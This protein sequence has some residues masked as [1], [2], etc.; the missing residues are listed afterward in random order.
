MLIEIIKNSYCTLDYSLTNLSYYPEE[1]RN[2]VKLLKPFIDTKK[3]II[4][5]KTIDILF[6]GTLN[7]RRTTI[8]D[9][10]KNYSG[11]KELNYKIEIVEK[12]FNNDLIELIEKSKIVINLHYYPNAILEL[13]RIHDILP[14]NCKII[15]ELPGDGDDIIVDKYN[16]IVT[17]IPVIEDDL[18]NIG[19]M[20]NSLSGCLQEGDPY[21]QDIIL[22]KKSE[23]I[24]KLNDENNDILNINVYQNL[25]HKYLLGLAQLD[26][27]I[28]YDIIQNNITTEFVERKYYAHLHCYDISKFDEMYGEYISKISQYFSPVITYSIGINTINNNNFIILK[29]PNK[30]MDIGG[31]FC[32]T[33]YLNDNKI[34]YEYILFLHSKSNPETR[35]KYFE[36]LINNLDDEFIKNITDFDGYFPDIQWEIVGDRLKMISGNPQYVDMNLPERNLLYRNE[37]LKYLGCNNGTNKFIEGHIYILSK[38]VVDKLFT[39]SLLYNILNTQ[40]SFDYQWVQGWGHKLKGH[41]SEVYKQFVERKLEPRNERSYDMYYE[42]VFERVILNCCDNHKIIKPLKICIIY[43][44]YERK[45]EQKNQTN[46]SFFIKYGLDKSRW[47]DMDITT[48]FVINGKQCEVLIPEREDLF[49]LKEDNCSDWEGW[50]NGIKYFENKYKEPIYESFTHL[51]LINASSFGP[52]YEDGMD[53]HWF[54]PFLNKMAETKSVACSPC[55][56][57][58][59]KEDLG[60]PGIRVLPV[61]SLIKIN[62]KIMNLLCNTLISSICKG[63]TCKAFI[64][65]YNTILG[66]KKDK[67]DAILTGEY[68]LS[69]ILLDNN[70]NISALNCNYNDTIRCDYFEDNNH[71]I[72]F[73]KNQQRVNDNFNSKPI[74]YDF[75]INFRNRKLNLINPFNECNI[76]YDYNIINRNSVGTTPFGINWNSKKELYDKFLKCDEYILFPHISTNN[77]NCAIYC[78]FNKNNIINENV[79]IALKTLMILEYDIIFCS[80]SIINNDLP[81][82]VNYYKNNGVGTDF[83]MWLDQ[84]KKLDNK[85]ERILLVNDSVI[86]PIHGINNMRKTID[87]IRNKSDLWGIWDSNEVSY[88]YCS[89]FIEFK[90]SVRKDIIKF[91][92][93][94]IINCKTSNDYII[95][96][97]TKLILYIK[98]KGFITECIS[99]STFY[100]N[101]KYF[102]SPE[103]TVVQL[104]N[105]EIFALKY[106]YTISYL[107]ENITPFLNYITRFLHYGGNGIISNGEKNGIYTPSKI[108]T[109]KYNLKTDYLAERSIKIAKKISILLSFSVD[110]QIKENTIYTAYSLLE[111]FDEIIVAS[112]VKYSFID[113]RITCLLYTSNIGFDFGNTIRVISYLTNTLQEL[114][115]QLLHIN[116]GMISVNKLHN[117]ICWCNDNKD[118]VYGLATNNKANWWDTHLVGVLRLYKGTAVKEFF[119]Y[120][121][122]F[123]YFTLY[124]H[125]YNN[126][127]YE[128]YISNSSAMPRKFVFGK[129]FIYSKNMKQIELTDGM[130]YKSKIYSE[131]AYYMYI[132][133]T[134]ELEIHK[135]FKDKGYLQLSYASSLEIEEPSG[136][137]LI[138]NEMWYL[139]NLPYV[140]MKRFSN[141]IALTTKYNEMKTYI[142]DKYGSLLI[143][144]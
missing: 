46:L 115:D 119:N 107:N 42:H 82:K 85:Y 139:N 74:L 37:L 27:K 117:F 109:S 77:K 59:P 142:H 45:N 79:I 135:Y 87:T 91:I 20:Y 131:G 29:I 56:N 124:P 126:N 50:F 2:K 136:I 13:F 83:I 89:A 18:S 25:F 88:H 63:S 5:E 49:I 35:K 76:N 44:Y 108:F 86:F 118:G 52:V 99:K 113:K 67:N 71:N 93:K 65:H 90:N 4:Y 48:L 101:N 132:V 14:Y 123:N 103:A 112:N 54:D 97:E 104:Y 66:K 64:N 140:K 15:S 95:N 57:L 36:P 53:R 102:H 39:E 8:L 100:P 55:L 81:F 34:S 26:D 137:P 141:R 105:K 72:I 122:N 24:D 92:E 110:G 120:I 98:S 38:K 68:G 10:L 40:T 129:D 128:N 111:F 70:Y 12:V 47:S 84:L 33:T 94:Q 17:F 144:I 21:G 134:W 7:K 69:R 61:F 116:D 96:I 58:L 130:S 60:G 125:L 30:G 133:T 1:I 114:P 41:F 32:V 106:K 31:K 19:E 80:T 43:V 16:D 23:L 62:K 11:E 73:I 121:N 75:C 6:I 3:N 22:N 78:H 28:K 143:N 138:E 9:R 127:F 51:C